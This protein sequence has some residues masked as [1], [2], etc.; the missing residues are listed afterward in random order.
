MKSITL[1][2][3]LAVNGMIKKARWKNRNIN[4]LKESEQIFSIRAAQ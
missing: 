4:N 2:L 3:L 1:I